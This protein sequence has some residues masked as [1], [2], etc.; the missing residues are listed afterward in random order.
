MRIDLAD[1]SHDDL[2]WVPRDARGL[3]LVRL[4]LSIIGHG[5]ANILDFF[6]LEPSES[7]FFGNL[8]HGEAVNIY[9]IFEP[10]NW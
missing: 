6:D 3:E 7:Q 4:A 2:V 1:L 5:Q 8:L 10:G 9:E